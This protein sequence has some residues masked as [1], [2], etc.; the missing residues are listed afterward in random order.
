M[1]RLPGEWPLLLGAAL[2]PVILVVNAVVAYHDV[3]ALLE[4]DRRLLHSYEVLNVAEELLGLVRD[5]ETGQRG[6]VITGQELYLEPYLRAI[7]RIDP[8]ATRLDSLVMGDDAQRARVAALRVRAEERLS[9]LRRTAAARDVEGFEAAREMIEEGTGRALMDSLRAVAAA[10]RFE[11]EASFSRGMEEASVAEQRAVYTLVLSTALA[12]AFFV[13]FLAMLRRLLRAR[14]EAAEGLRQRRDE[15]E[16]L[17]LQR[18]RA[19]EGANAELRA[20]AEELR[21]SNRELEDFAFIASHDL[22]EPLRKMQL[23]G[24]RVARRY[25]DALPAAAR[26]DLGRVTEAAARMRRLVDDLLA[27]A[28]AGRRAEARPVDLGA[29][30]AAVLDDLEEA[31]AEAGA[32]VEVGPLP[33]V[34]GDPTQ[35]RQLFQNLLGNALKFRREGVPPEVRVSAEHVG[36]VSYVDRGAEPPSV[37]IAVADNGIGFEPHHAERIFSPFERLHTQGSFPGTGIGLAVCRRVA[38]H[39]GGTIFAHGVRGEGA[40]FVVTLPARPPLAPP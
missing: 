30:V 12:L 38:E 2:L 7:P 20:A 5:A 10:I 3:R 31:V 1:R 22:Q 27:Y 16:A 9:Y 8:L 4:N 14:Q 36:V 25:A 34:E 37:R 26:E 21:R 32:R 23:F 33:T 29:V 24:E 28:R 18:T 6:Y 17:V 39:H 15:L 13:G 19:L 11:E 40:T 35:L